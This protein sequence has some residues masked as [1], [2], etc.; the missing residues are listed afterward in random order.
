MDRCCS[1]GRW[2]AVAPAQKLATMSWSLSIMGTTW[3]GRRAVSR[4]YLKALRFMGFWPLL[5]MSGGQ[6]NESEK[7][8][9]GL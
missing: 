6:T 1:A 9:N 8:D 3:E 5:S 2:D 4:R 7:M